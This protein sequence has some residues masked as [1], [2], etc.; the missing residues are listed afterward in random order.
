MLALGLFRLLGRFLYLFDYLWYRDFFCRCWLSNE[1]FF[2]LVY[3]VNELLQIL[4]VPVDH[5]KSKL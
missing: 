3:E 4:N 1:P 2:F 5:W